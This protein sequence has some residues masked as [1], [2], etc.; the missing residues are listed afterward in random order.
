M[1]DGN[2]HVCYFFNG[3]AS[4]HTA[5]VASE[6]EVPGRGTTV[7]VRGK[8]WHV[9]HVERKKLEGAR[10]AFFIVHLYSVHADWENLV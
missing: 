5:R 10:Q 3:V 9:S 2:I 8:H 1:G 6:S 4:A 7:E